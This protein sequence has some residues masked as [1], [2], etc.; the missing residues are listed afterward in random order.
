MV[1]FGFY[2]DGKRRCLTFSYDDNRKEDRELVR[3]FNEYGMKGSF[4]INSDNLDKNENYVTS[5]EVAELYKGHEVSC[6][7]LTHPFLERLPYE[8]MSYEILEDRKRLEA[9]CGYPVRGMSYPFGTY[10]QNVVRALPYFGIKYARTILT[11]NKFELPD[12][13]LMWHPTCHH[14]NALLD[15]VEAFKKARP[16]NVFYVWGHSFEFNMHGNWDLIKTFCDKMSEDKDVWYA[17]NIELYDYITALRS[18]H[19][20][21]D[22]K[23]VYNPTLIDVWLDVDGSAVKIPS[24]ETVKL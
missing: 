19:F 14:N 24:G 3:I 4:H 22:R 6:H 9:L 12:N 5:A 13:F 11:S 21:A 15:R 8:E 20:T 18:L 16:L 23:S 17:T 10:D 2:K 7:G 1:R